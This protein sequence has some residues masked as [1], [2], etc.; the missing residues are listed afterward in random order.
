MDFAGNDR[1]RIL[2]QLGAGGMGI[3]YEAVDELRHQKVA[4]KTLQR[5]DPD[6]LLRFKKEFRLARELEH[7]NLARLGELVEHE[8]TWFFTMELV[9]GTDFLSY[10]RPQLATMP[11]PATPR[12]ATTLLEM[13]DHEAHQRI[14]NSAPLAGT[15]DEERLRDALR[16]LVIGLEALHAVGNVHR[17]VKPANVHVT[18]DGRVVLLDFGMVHGSHGADRS[19]V[20]G[21]LGTPAYMAP[22][23]AAAVSIGPAAD[24][25]S[26]GVMLYEAL[27]GTL[28]HGGTIADLLRDKLRLDPP[29]PC[30]RA[31]DVPADL[32]R[33]CMEL[34]HRKPEKRPTGPEIVRRLSPEAAVSSRPRPAAATEGPVFVGRT[35]PLAELEEAWRACAGE[36]A[37][38]V[39]VDGA[40]GMGKTALLRAFVSRVA[41][42]DGV[43]VLE[44]R[45]YEHESVPYKALDSVVD[46]LSH[47]LRWMSYDKLAELV[48]LHGALLPRV[49][50]VLGRVPALME[51]SRSAALE[52]PPAELRRRIFVAM[53]E[54]FVRLADRNR[55]LLV[56]DDL[57]WADRDS[58]MLL[59]E[60]LRPPAA[61]PMMLVLASRDPELPDPHAAKG[62]HRPVWAPEDLRRISLGPLDPE[63]TLAV[64]EAVVARS[65]VEGEI[66][67]KIIA[68][69]SEGHPLFVQ[70]L[71]RHVAENGIDP[72][73][74]P[75]LDDVLARRIAG[76]PRDARLVLDLSAVASGA[77][78]ED[79]LVEAAELSEGATRRAISRLVSEHLVSAEHRPEG[80]AVEPFHHR[81][82]E[83]VLA[84]LSPERSRECHGRMARALAVSGKADPELLARH[85]LGAGDERKAAECSLLA[86]ENAA[87]ALAFDRAAELQRRALDLGVARDESAPVEWCKLGDHLT[88][89]GRCVEAAEAYLESARGRGNDPI[90]RGLAAEQYVRGGHFDRGM[91]I[92]RGVLAALGIGVPGS[93]W[94]AV[95]FTVGMRLWLGI[96]GYA[97]RKHTATPEEIR[98]VDL[99][100]NL[101]MVASGADTIYGTWMSLRAL[102]E[103]LRAGE[104]GRVARALSV[105]AGWESGMHG[106]TN[107]RVRRLL[108][109]AKEV[110][111]GSGWLDGARGIV[112]FMSARYDTSLA[113]LARA[114]AR[115][116]ETPG[117]R[118]ESRMIHAFDTFALH[119]TGRLADVARRSAVR[120]RGAADDGDL[121]HSAFHRLGPANL[122]CWLAADA[123]ERALSEAT[124]GLSTWSRPRFDVIA[125]MALHSRASIALYQDRPREAW[126]DIER[127]RPALAASMLLFVPFLR[128][129]FFELRGRVALACAAEA[130][131]GAER[132]LFLREVTRAVKKLEGRRMPT[133]RELAQLLRAGLA[134][135]RGDRD[136]ANRHLAAAIEGL[137]ALGMHGQATAARR[138][139]GELTG[140]DEGKSL[141][142]SADAAFREQGVVRPDRWTY[143]L[144]PFGNAHAE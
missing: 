13:S 59:G 137:D 42:E 82:R 66:D 64:A 111:S 68:E 51:K 38:T 49:F 27:T 86:A 23:Q 114:E 139:L 12:D 80:R 47:V 142:E 83:S 102:M 97:P 61:P 31:P 89:A 5:L 144:A 133:G 90:L 78:P 41:A 35:A 54:L 101:A 107:G 112:D 9:R 135:A 108:Q 16:Q 95:L 113:A 29:P 63:E 52:L 67:P 79:V 18:P 44:G 93:P 6:G 98:R 3:V 4:L 87:A 1:F 48:P 55:L 70:E 76:L 65:G 123:P 15:F 74:R 25:Y 127:C 2:R 58:L 132:D 109:V 104:P 129:G 62:A 103:A 26:V 141:V 134:L 17:D 106:G 56:L 136:G 118:F 124:L 92:A 81:V 46:R 14:G 122:A 10:V 115:F 20:M 96:R 131:P 37:V 45:S 71:V 110:D 94:L 69:E 11:R 60:I 138:R 8:G 7:P 34:L 85:H 32:D 30:V 40:P 73:R 84:A 19:T 33:L 53:R 36:T 39:F 100:H 105:D 43:M 140:G 91:E 72:E 121:Y 50:P 143:L 75:R 125:W 130:K 116:E 126:D 24:F 117:M 57:Q 28:P 88:H 119:A 128:L 77:T 99:L 22:E 21:V 120:L